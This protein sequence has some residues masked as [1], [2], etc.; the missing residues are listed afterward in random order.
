LNSPLFVCKQ[1]PEPPEK[2]FIGFVDAKRGYLKHPSTVLKLQCKKNET[3][4]MALP[5]SMYIPTSRKT[6]LRAEVLSEVSKEETESGLNCSLVL[7]EEI[8]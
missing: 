7:L 4:A 2:E 6:S 8:H 1:E 5:A 3:L